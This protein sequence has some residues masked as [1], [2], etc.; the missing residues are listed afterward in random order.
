MGP[1]AWEQARR[2]DD[3]WIGA[4]HFLLALLETPSV[5]SDALLELGVTYEVAARLVSEWRATSEWSLPRYDNER[6]VSPNPAYQVMGR[7][8]AFVAASGHPTPQPEH[9]LLALVWT[10]HGAMTELHALGA[11]QDRILDGLRRRG[12]RVPG[13]DPPM[14]RP[15]RGGQ[16][17]EIDAD[18]LQPIIDVLHARYP[19]GSEAR[20]GFNGVPDKPARRRVDAEEGIDL[21]AAVREARRRVNG[22]R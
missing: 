6:G 8:E 14:Y 21:D 11:T 9:W 12:V 10:D 20:W 4:E 1:D 19:A 18:E 2:L 22:L 5:A 3:G 15:W 17:V 13:V 7:A 16:T